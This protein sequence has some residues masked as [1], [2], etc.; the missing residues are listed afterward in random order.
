MF[1]RAGVF[2]HQFK[3][4]EVYREEY[5]KQFDECDAFMISGSRLSSYDKVPWI[6]RLLEYVLKLHRHRKKTVG[7]CFGHQCMA[8]A[9]GGRVEKS[10]NGWG[11]GV[12]KYNILDSGTLSNLNGSQVKLQCSHQDQVVEMPSCAAPILESEFCPI[13]GMRVDNHFISIQPHPEFCRDF[14]EYLLR[15]REDELGPRFNAAMDSLAMETHANEVSRSLS[16]FID[17]K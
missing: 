8:I 1:E 3:S 7:I 9:L 15:S 4:Y 12:H 10:P 2:H 16:A 5:P 17:L 6:E 13:A 11:V 14:A